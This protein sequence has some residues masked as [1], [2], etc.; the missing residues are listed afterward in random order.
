[1]HRAMSMLKEAEVNPSHKL[2]TLLEVYQA[3]KGIETGMAGAKQQVVI[4]TKEC[5]KMSVLH[6]RALASVSGP[7]LAKWGGELAGL[8]ESVRM[9]SSLTVTPFLENA[10]QRELLGQYQVG[11]NILQK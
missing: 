4:F 11:V 8:V 6:Q 2:H 10:G 1:M 7:Q 9:S 3:H 5:E